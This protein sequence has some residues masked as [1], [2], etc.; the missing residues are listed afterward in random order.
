MTANMTTCEDVSRV[1]VN[2]KLQALAVTMHHMRLTKIME[3]T[4]DNL[5]KI[6]QIN[7]EIGNK[8]MQRDTKKGG[9]SQFFRIVV[10][11]LKLHFV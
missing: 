8:I 2:L 7:L 5:A 10:L 3:N 1:I 9:L 6:L 11:V 4:L